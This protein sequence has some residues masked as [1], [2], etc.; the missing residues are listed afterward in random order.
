M[1]P[2]SPRH[3][4]DDGGAYPGDADG[5]ESGIDRAAEGLPRH[6]DRFGHGRGEPAQQVA[7]SRPPVEG[8]EAVTPSAVVD[9]DHRDYRLDEERQLPPEDR[10]DEL[11][12]SGGAAGTLH[13]A[14]VD[15]YHLHRGL[16]G[17][18]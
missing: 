12:R 14:R 10:E 17:E 7:L 9:V 11:S 13:G 15:G 3:R 1:P 18:S 5:K 4:G 6:L 16:L 8:S 2:G